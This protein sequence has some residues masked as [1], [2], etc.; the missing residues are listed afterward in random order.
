[1][2]SDEQSGQS[3]QAQQ[4]QVQS[5]T[6]QGLQQDSKTQEDGG[7]ALIKGMTKAIVAIEMHWCNK[8]GSFEM[9]DTPSLQEVSY[10]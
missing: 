2:P 1:M 7:S 10:D 8:N 6:A 9:K 4:S 5:Q 3:S